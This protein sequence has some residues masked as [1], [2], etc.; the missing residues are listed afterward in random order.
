MGFQANCTH[1]RSTLE[2]QPVRDLLANMLTF[3]GRLDNYEEL[4]ALL[5][6]RC[7]EIS[8]S[9]IV[10]S[11][12]ER[13]G[14][15]CFSYFVGDWALALWSSK[16]QSLYLA[17]DHAGTRTLYFERTSDGILWSTYL[18]T[19]LIGRKLRELDKAY[20]ACYLASQPLR[21]LTPY[22]GV[23]A[24]TPAHYLVFHQTTTVSKVHWNWVA[25]ELI[26]Y[27]TDAEYEEHFLSLFRCAVKRRTGPGSPILAHLSG[28]MDS[29]AIVCMS[30][31]IRR[32]EGAS[33]EDQLDTISYYDD[34]EPH[35]DDRTYFTVV[36]RCRK[37]VGTHVDVSAYARTFEPI[38]RSEGF[39][40]VP[41][42]DRSS[43][44]AE[45]DLYDLAV[46]R[47]FRVILSGIGGDE[48]LGGVPTGIPE[49]ADYLV[50]GRLSALIRVGIA[51][52]V[53]T[54]API[55]HLLLDTVRSL[56]GLYSRRGSTGVGALPPWL[57][58]D[59]IV[60]VKSRAS[61]FLPM[62]PSLFLR[63]SAIESGHTWWKLLETMPHQ[64]PSY[65]VRYEYRYPYLDRDL[66]D[67][68]LRVPR[69]Q[70]VRPGRRRSLMRRALKSIVPDEV[71][72]R[73]RKGYLSRSPALSLLGRRHQIEA[74]WKDSLLS[75]YGLADSSA[76]IEHLGSIASLEGAM[77]VTPLMRAALF[78]IWLR[79]LHGIA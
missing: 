60:A 1:L 64:T 11:A 44:Q 4:C 3:D 28:G 66:V 47:G 2:S 5:D 24:V 67:F 14:E 56:F 27:K 9:Q 17:R 62:R 36:E 57:T 74:K 54:R 16:D 38:A 30:D 69:E 43:L 35:W 61:Q 51:W 21:D 50:A 76:L 73:P 18:E 41:G 52:C 29:T 23:T 79:A 12:F 71:L 49:L 63:P 42:A 45:H 68:L 48:L 31:L 34:T 70:L 46:R 75:A 33:T 72:E 65:T 78:E 6:M 22:K 20:A 77:W 13:W 37:K 40:G 8:D 53:T 26:W 58:S 25:K 10:L 55:V 15:R 7:S 19:F 39:Y 32:G 59:L